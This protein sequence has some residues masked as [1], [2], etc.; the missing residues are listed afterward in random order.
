[1]DRMVATHSTTRSF[2]ALDASLHVPLA[3]RRRGQAWAL[4]WV[5]HGLVLVLALLSFK[6]KTEEPPPL[7]RLVFVEPPPPPAAPAGPPTLVPVPVSPAQPA[8][9]VEQAKT[10]VKPKPIPPKRL[11]ISKRA[12]P[13]TTPP[14]EVEPAP[15]PPTPEQSTTTEPETTV[16]GG[17]GGTTNGPREGVIG[18]VSN[19]VAGGVIGGQGTGPL[20]VGQAANPPVLISR[21]TPHYP[22]AARLQGIEGLVLLEAILDRDGRIEEN[23]TVLQ[24]IPALDDAA[25]QALRRWRFQPARDHQRQPMRVILEVP[26]RFILK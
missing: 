3:Q 26:I 1:M 23:V 11:T 6:T 7:V 25:V 12:K 5:A 2:S 16:T 19:G 10:P 22:R 9:V 17:G 20:P 13:R 4:S 8:V 18:G 14:A 21:V 24:S 15:P